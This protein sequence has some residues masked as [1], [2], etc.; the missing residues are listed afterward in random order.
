MAENKRKGSVHTGHRGRLRKRFLAE[1]AAAFE[2]HQLLELLLFYSVP[3]ADTNALAH[4]LLDAF[5]SMQALLSAPPDET[6]RRGGLGQTTA[7]L[8]SMFLPLKRRMEAD[9]LKPRIVLDS[10]V[11]AG[12]YAVRLFMPPGDAARAYLLCQD[13][14]CR[15]LAAERLAA[16]DFAALAANP[17]QIVEPAVRHK[18][19]RVILV[20]ALGRGSSCTEEA[21]AALASGAAESLS[22]MG[23]RLTDFIL[24]REQRYRSMAA[25]GAPLLGYD[26]EA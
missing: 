12:E 5:G 2:D 24:V 10:A 3:R 25:H 14:A 1:G 15:L 6:M 17:A 9:A 7:A 20:C 23:L 21:A 13:S 18:S 19:A 8:L 22:R 26:A 4:R 11:A 16:P